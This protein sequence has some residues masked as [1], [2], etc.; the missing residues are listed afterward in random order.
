MNKIK[1]PPRVIHD[2]PMPMKAD[3]YTIGSEDFA[4]EKAKEK[5]VYYITYRR[6]LENINPD[7]YTKGDNRIIFHGLSRL[8]DY[9]FYVATTLGEI[10]EAEQ[11][12]EKAQATMLG[13]KAYPFPKHLW[14]TIVKDYNGRPPIKIKAVREGSVIYP[15][16][17]CVVIESMVEGFGEMAAWFESTL[18]KVWSS[19]ELITQLVHWHLYCQSL[20]R[21]VYGNTISEEQIMSLA[22]LMLHSFGC[23]AGM[24]PQE[25]EWLGADALLV[26]NGT[27]TFSGGF[28]AWKNSNKTDG[29]FVSVPALAHR[30]V[31]AYEEEKDCYNTMYNNSPDGTIN[32]MVSDCYSPYDASVNY[33]L[34]LALDAKAK[35]NNKVIVD[36]FDSGN[37]QEQILWW[38]KLAH[39]HGLSTVE[40]ILN[41]EW[42]FS[43][44]TKCLEGDGMTF[45]KMKEIN[46]ELM[47]HGFPPFS[48]CPYGQGGGMRNDLKRDNLSA[49]YALCA[50]G[51][52]LRPVCKFSDTLEKTT[53][54]G[55]F[56][57]L[58]SKEALEVN[59]TIVFL[60]E[61]GEDVM[62][63]YYNGAD[64]WEP[65]KEGYGEKFEVIRARIWEQMNSMPKS[66]STE[67]NHN[68]PA[69]DAIR[70]KRI[71]L[72]QHYAPKK[73]TQ[74]Y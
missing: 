43:T 67:E 57:L 70:A 23:R 50:V 37:A 40:K 53:L 1:L 6:L 47:E 65:F 20:V 71:E 61:A 41:K 46:K 58:R 68:Y 5:S 24:T 63:D 52:E 16:E 73:L 31:Q 21:A 69:S 45:K 26:F 11:S 8:I 25:S 42:R 22:S 55:P 44:N 4:A 2:T 36:R 54:P 38:C 12:L 66:L 18:L 13:L 56:K 3:A 33:L 32:S 74:N 7:V 27:D 19:S 59:K 14:E 49:K 15:N 60:S 10:N 29:I 48:W 72:V 9:L 30:N 62:V 64:I 35:G 34:P 17:P 39:K 51:N 28:Q